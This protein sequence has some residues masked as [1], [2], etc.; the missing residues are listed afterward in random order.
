MT[1]K[2]LALQYLRR[3]FFPQ[4]EQQ[5]QQV[6]L[7]KGCNLVFFMAFEMFM[8]ILI[9]VMFFV[10]GAI[11]PAITLLV[12]SAT[13]FVWFPA[14]ARCRT[15]EEISTVVAWMF[16]LGMAFLTFLGLLEGP[17]DT[18]AIAAMVVL[19]MIMSLFDKKGGTSRFSVACFLFTIVD[20]IVIKALSLQGWTIPTPAVFLGENAYPHGMSPLAGEMYTII[21]LLC[22]CFV[23]FG[24]SSWQSRTYFYLGAA[25]LE[26]I[27]RKAELIENRA[28]LFAQVSVLK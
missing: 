2:R 22:V 15:E 21:V 27:S 26:E 5:T 6:T 25:R 20:I 13:F 12:V 19:P 4:L 18:C 9:S 14:V 16:F 11:V 3:C 17:L 24:V 8:C 23:N 1:N 10:T 28:T 7:D